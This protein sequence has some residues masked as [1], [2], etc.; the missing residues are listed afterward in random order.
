VGAY[1]ATYKTR[2]MSSAFTLVGRCRWVL[3][4]ALATVP[5][6]VLAAAPAVV[7]TEAKVGQVD[8][9]AVVVK[10]QGPS[11]QET[12]LQVACLFEYVE[13]DI[14]KAPPALPAA[15]NGMV[16]LDQALHGLVTDLRKSG[17]FGGHALE[18]LLIVPPKGTIPAER[19]LLI[20]LG[21]RKTFTPTLMRQVGAVGM[22]E[23]LR[24]GVRSYSHASDLKDGGIEA[25]VAEVADAVLGGA[26]DALR[27]QRYLSEKGA[28][29]APS[30]HQ[31]TLLAGPA[32][33]ADTTAT[34]RQLLSRPTGH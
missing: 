5:P 21:D 18:T 22:R 23:A 27:A 12:P 7:G 33:F 32:F 19:L 10:V 3:L 2:F 13:G 11:T 17:K 29:P 9:L 16:H 15:V 28:S 6:T 26:F 20:G 4:I 31:L 14:F 1:F 8:G 34:A 24:L 25:P 30:V